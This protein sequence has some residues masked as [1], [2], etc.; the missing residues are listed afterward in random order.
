MRFDN[1]CAMLTQRNAQAKRCCQHCRWSDS[2]HFHLR[3]NTARGAVFNVD[4]RR[5]VCMFAQQI[6]QAK[7]ECRMV[8]A[9]SGQTE[10]AA[11]I[12]VWELVSS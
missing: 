6:F 2:I 8:I 4:G 11:G 3:S 5:S 10:V 1:L 12:N 7:Q 9:D